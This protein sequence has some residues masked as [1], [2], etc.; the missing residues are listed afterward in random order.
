MGD[1]VRAAN[2]KRRFSKGYTTNWSYVIFT[3]TKNINGTFPNYKTLQLPEICKERLLKKTKATGRENDR[4][5][6]SLN[7]TS[8]KSKSCCPSLQKEIISIVQ[9]NA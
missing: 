6:H 1:L 4:A 8:I 7:V 2:S 3:I 9:T 5:L